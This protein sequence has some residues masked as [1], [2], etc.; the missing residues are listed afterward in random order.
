MRYRERDRNTTVKRP[1]LWRLGKI[2][3]LRKQIIQLA[4]RL[5]RPHGVL[6][7]SLASNDAVEQ[8]ILSYLP[9]KRTQGHHQLA[10]FMQHPSL[11]SPL[12][13][14]QYGLGFGGLR[15]KA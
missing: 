5:I 7:L 12:T 8:T 3:T 9:S 2:G 14:S 1:V 11:S 6:S 15:A 13:T 10:E 4:G